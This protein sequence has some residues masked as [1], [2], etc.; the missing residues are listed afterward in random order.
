MV[1]T[2]LVK[3]NEVLALCDLLYNTRDMLLVNLQEKKTNILSY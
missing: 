3:Q 1:R 2:D